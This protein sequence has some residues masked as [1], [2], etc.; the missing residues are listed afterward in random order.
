MLKYFMV[1]WKFVHFVDNNLPL[2][3]IL[4]EN[5]L[6]KYNSK[7]NFS[8]NNIDILNDIKG[9]KEIIKSK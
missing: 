1:T 8:V 4:K 9:V 7:W 3:T 6:S 2:Q 5:Q